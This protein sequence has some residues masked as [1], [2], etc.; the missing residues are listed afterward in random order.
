YIHSFVLFLLFLAS[1]NGS[2]FPGP[3]QDTDKVKRERL[4]NRVLKSTIAIN[5][6][7]FVFLSVGIGLLVV[8]G[9]LLWISNSL[10]IFGLIVLLLGIL[11]SLNGGCL[12]YSLILIKAAIDETCN[13][14]VFRPE[15]LIDVDYPKQPRPVLS[16]E[17]ARS[18]TLQI[19][20]PRQSARESLPPAYEHRVSSPEPDWSPPPFYV[21]NGVGFVS[22]LLNGP[23]IHLIFTFASSCMI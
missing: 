2:I 16:R 22:P 17:Y 15:E 14:R 8:Y 21:D 5:V 13:P 6:L 11:L 20:S 12:I 18:M 19:S 23:P 3:L 10:A 4:E 7:A 9:H 1:M